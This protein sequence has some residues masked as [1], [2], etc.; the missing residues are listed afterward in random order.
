MEVIATKQKLLKKVHVESQSF[1][2][3]AMIGPYS[4][5]MCYKDFCFISGM[6]GLKS[7]SM[8]LGDFEEQ[9][10]LPREHVEAVKSVLSVSDK[11]EIALNWRKTNGDKNLDESIQ[12]FAYDSIDSGTISIS[13]LPRNA[14]LEIEEILWNAE[15]GSGLPVIK[16]FENLREFKNF[17]LDNCRN[18]EFSVRLFHSSNP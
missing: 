14:N 12:E 3:P 13:N 15:V 18:D 7:F 17:V 4:Q 10:M 6:I 5:A 8:E 11:D 2:A 9:E 1:W 16:Y